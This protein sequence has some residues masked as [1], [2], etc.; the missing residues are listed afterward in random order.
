MTASVRDQLAVQFWTACMK[1]P[2]EGKM[3]K[4]VSNDFHCLSKWSY[5]KEVRWN[6]INEMIG[7]LKLALWTAKIEDAKV[8]DMGRGRLQSSHMEKPFLPIPTTFMKVENAWRFTFAKDEKG[9]EKITSLHID[10][11][12]G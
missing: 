6:N 12:C 3:R 5:G 7:G 10:T 2:N 11:F 1:E 9:E 8:E 4:L